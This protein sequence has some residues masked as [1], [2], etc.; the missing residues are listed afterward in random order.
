[1]V[2]KMNGLLLCL[3]MAALCFA[4]VLVWCLPIEL[5]I[6]CAIGA[7]LVLLGAWRIYR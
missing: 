2:L 7:P 4:A 1:M 3:L 6:G 5:R